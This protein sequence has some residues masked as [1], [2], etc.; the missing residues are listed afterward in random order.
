D[1]F[2]AYSPGGAPGGAWSVAT[3]KGAVAVDSGR[4]YS[5]T[6]AVKV[7]ADATGGYRSAMMVLK[8]TGFLPTANNVVYGRMMFWLESAPEGTVHWTFIDGQGVVPGKGYH[9][10]YRYGGQHPIQQNGTFAGSQLMA[11]YD[12]PDSYQ[13]PPV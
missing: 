13:N 4:A 9:A 6:R 1:D 10:L 12:T 11:N 8:N 7:S 3:N 5:G 2:E